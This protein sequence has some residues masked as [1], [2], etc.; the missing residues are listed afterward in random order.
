MPNLA[1]LLAIILM[2]TAAHSAEA[3]W[4]FTVELHKTPRPSSFEVTLRNTSGGELVF[5][6]S[7]AVD[8]DY[9]IVVEHP[10]GAVVQK[11]PIG[12]MRA[13][14]A[15]LVDPTRG[16]IQVRTSWSVYTRR[17]PANG[18][19]TET[20][21]LD[22]YYAL[23]P[24]RYYVAVRPDFPIAKDHPASYSNAVEIVVPN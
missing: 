8:V 3:A 22:D 7:G 15:P 10:D 21:D 4:P 13:G 2:S 1:F 16:T 23:P 19:E 18:T 6:N 12:K 17:L 20:F 11:T 14:E 9:T 24:G 5:G